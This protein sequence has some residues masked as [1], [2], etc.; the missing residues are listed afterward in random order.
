MSNETKTQLIF[1]AE[2]TKT[3][4][5]KLMNPDY[6][7]AYDFQPDEERTLTIKKVVIEN[8]DVKD[9]KKEDLPIIHFVEPSKPMVMNSTNGKMLGNI[10]ESN[11]IEDWVGKS[12]TIQVKKIKA[13]GE[14]MDALRVKNEKVVKKLP[15]LT[16]GSK[17][18]NACL[19]RYKADNSVLDKIKQS[20]TISPETL[21]ALTNGT[22]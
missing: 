3:H 11:Y 15:T 20:Y 1:R 8:V 12:F 21:E 13:F 4:Y 22:V 9:G 2:P 7:G 5:K 18:F 16:V 17:A 19:E 6:L 10:L 14:W